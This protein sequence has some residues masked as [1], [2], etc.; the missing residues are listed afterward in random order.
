MDL[1][2]PQRLGVS[3]WNGNTPAH[4][5][6]GLLQAHGFIN[7]DNV[8]DMYRMVDRFLGEHLAVWQMEHTA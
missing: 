1:T 3:L 2:V 4:P 5:I 7:S 6:R 8:I